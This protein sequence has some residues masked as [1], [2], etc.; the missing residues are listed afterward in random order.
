M[1]V[2]KLIVAL[3]LVAAAV[4]AA[5]LAADVRSWPRALASGDA[6]Y[7]ASPSSATWKPPTHLGNL[8]R[9]ALGVTSD[10]EYRRALR[11]YRLSAGRQLRLDNALDVSTARGRAQ[12]ALGSVAREASTQP[13][14][15]ARTLLGVLAF[16]AV[17]QGGGP[18]ELSQAVLDFD[19]AIR[20]DPSN[21]TAKYDLEL[22]LRL[23][24]AHGVRASPGPGPPVDATGRKGAGTGAG[25]SGY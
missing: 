5:L 1:R 2:V 13:A 24:A 17:G 21:E 12:D 6:V 16:S 14:S 11:L 7:A 18:T 15:Q 4:L 19:D 20:I 3:A 25:G 22:L 8:S 10:V 23:S 9:S